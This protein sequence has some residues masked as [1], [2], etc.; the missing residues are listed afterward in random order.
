MAVYNYIY[1]WGLHKRTGRIEWLGTSMV[2]SIVM[3]PTSLLVHKSQRQVIEP[4]PSLLDL[5][6]SLSNLNIVSIIAWCSVN[7]NKWQC[8]NALLHFFTVLLSLSSWL[9]CYL[10]IGDCAYVLSCNCMWYYIYSS[11][12]CFQMWLLLNSFIH[13]EVQAVDLCWEGDHNM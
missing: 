4:H 8:G 1:S 11:T 5:Q 3:I 12:I 10:P 7:A 13:H 9:P 2:N 6:S